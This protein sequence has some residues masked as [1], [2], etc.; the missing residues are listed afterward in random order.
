MAL[1]PIDLKEPAA[2]DVRRV[3]PRAYSEARG[4][5]DPW[6]MQTQCLVAGDGGSTIE[7]NVRFLHVTERKVGRRRDDAC[8]VSTL[9]F[10]E[11]LRVGDDLYLPWDEA[12]EREVAVGRFR[13]SDLESPREGR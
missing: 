6:I 3:Y 11:E 1:P 9:E 13:L 10:V 8:N 7:V 5:D 4:Q 2:L 12:T